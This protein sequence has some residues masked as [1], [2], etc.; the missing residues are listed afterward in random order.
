MDEILGEEFCAYVE[1]K[2]F[3]LWGLKGSNKIIPIAQNG[4]TLGIDD[5]H[6]DKSMSIDDEADDP[7]E[8]SCLHSKLNLLLTTFN[9]S[10]Y[11]A[12]KGNTSWQRKTL[13]WFASV[14]T[15]TAGKH[16]M[17]HSIMLV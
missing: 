1:W 12:W 14:P 7:N 16:L 9:L 8:F 11:A 6:D 10:K 2:E 17:L 13:D 5:L 3:D 15:K 4:I